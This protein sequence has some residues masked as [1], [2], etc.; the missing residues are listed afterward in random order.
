LPTP[1]GAATPEPGPPGSEYE[2][3]PVE[4]EDLPGVAELLPH[5]TGR[6]PEWNRG[7]LTWKYLDNP[8]VDRPLGIV[9]RAG[10]RVVG[11]RGYH[12]TPWCVP[13]AGTRTLVLSPG[14][15]TV[16]P[17]H[18]RRGLSVRM[19]ARAMDE[20]HPDHR[21]FLN[22]TAGASS[23]PGYVRMGFVRLHDK[24]RLLRL[25]PLRLARSFVPLGG[26]GADGDAA[27]PRGVRPGEFG[28]VEVSL[29]PR[30][31]AMARVAME[32]SP[33]TPK[34]TPLQEAGFFRWYFRAP[35]ARHVFYYLRE[36]G[37]VTGYVVVRL[38]PPGR[39]ATILDNSRHSV[40]PVVELLRFLVRSKP[41]GVLWIYSFTPSRDLRSAMG[42]LGFRDDGLIERLRRRANR[43][44]PLLV[45]PVHP[46]PR[47]EDWFVGDLDIRRISSWEIPEIRSDA[48]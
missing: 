36:E 23:V 41:A 45:R 4:A 30:P 27:V 35:G 5:L 33:T 18:R 2:I 7:Y 21:I 29:E 15:T 43:V 24:S 46:T 12:A 40:A 3:R 37:R 22:M 42:T 13:G 11:F 9:A 39:L 26:G 48:I 32:P 6:D 1:S 10:D 34:L 25:H 44:W 38:E 8:F 31:E 20:L 16:H 19:G 47:E 14:D 17:E 28:N